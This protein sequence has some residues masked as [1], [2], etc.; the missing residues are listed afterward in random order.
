MGY[1]P[2]GCRELDMTERITHTHDL[3]LL[4]S[5]CMCIS[6]NSKLYIFLNKNIFRAVLGL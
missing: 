3:L 2:C 4:S 5:I 1:S 6:H